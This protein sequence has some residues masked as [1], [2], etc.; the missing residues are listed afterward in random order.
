MDRPF[1]V[2]SALGSRRVLSVKNGR[3]VITTRDN[4]NKSQVWVFD[5][6]TM[7]LK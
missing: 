3:T 7:T 4:A 1:R 6:K 2:V 5:G